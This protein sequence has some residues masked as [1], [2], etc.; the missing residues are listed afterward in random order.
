FTSNLDLPVS[1]GDSACVIVY[2][3]SDPYPA[4]L[5]AAALPP[6][7]GSLV[8]GNK[9]NEA[10][11]SKVGSA[12]DFNADGIGDFAVSTFTYFETPEP[13]AIVVYGR[14]SGFGRLYDVDA[15]DSSR[16]IEFR[17]A[18]LDTYHFLVIGAKAGDLNGDGV[19]DLVIGVPDVTIDWR[20]V[21]ETHLIF[22]PAIRHAAGGAPVDLL[23]MTG[24]EGLTLRGGTGLRGGTLYGDRS[25]DP[26]TIAPDFSG[27]GLADALIGASAAQPAGY[28]AVVFGNSAPTASDSAVL[29]PPQLEDDFVANGTTVQTTFSAVYEDDDP[30]GGV[31]IVANTTP[32]QEGRWQFRAPGSPWVDIDTAVSDQSAVVLAH[33]GFLRFV[34]A[35]DFFGRPQAL[36]VRLWDGRL[37]STGPEVDVTAAIGSLGGVSND[38][39]IVSLGISV[40]GVNDPPT[41][42]A[43]DPPPVLT[44]EPVAISAWAD[45]NAGATNE[46]QIVSFHVTGVSRPDFFQQLPAVAPDGT[47]IYQAVPEVIGQSDFVVTAMD[48]GGT[49][50]GGSNTS[51]PMGFVLTFDQIIFASGFEQ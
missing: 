3:R 45:F 24:N 31:A 33:D 26:V 51:E 19:D 28:T 12:G 14:S 10:F 25:G 35:P 32:A 22:G 46:N 40:V 42:V 5:I 8:Y 18:G 34:P 9:P 48:D 21:G 47:L 49:A 16:H 36:A 13:R 41:F 1:E 27:N 7:Q 38:V 6:E 17:R 11:C 43:K 50:N 39:D 2:G 44:G 15:Q 23:G 20:T 4:E 30:I 29:L 37:L